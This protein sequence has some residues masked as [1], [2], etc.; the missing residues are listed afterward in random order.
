MYRLH[1]HSWIKEEAVPASESDSSEVA[2]PDSP[3]P[4]TPPYD[5]KKWPVELR[6][7]MTPPVTPKTPPQY[8]RV[9]RI[10]PPPLLPKVRRAS[11]TPPVI[12]KFP[13]ADDDS[14]IS[15][16]ALWGDDDPHPRGNI[17]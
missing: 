1:L 10:E 11:S 17:D 4:K 7:S 16:A 6:D 14:W 15:E 9:R 3:V 12:P 5:F 2:G 13:D 8:V